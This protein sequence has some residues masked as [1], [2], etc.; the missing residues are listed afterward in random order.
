MQI[1]D[2]KSNLAA[3]MKIVEADNRIV[4]DS[5]GSYI[6][7]KHTG[8]RIQIRHENGC[9]VFDMWVPA[10]RE[11]R[12]NPDSRRGAKRTTPIAATRN[13][14]FKALEE[15]DDMEVGDI[16]DEGDRRRAVF[17]RQEC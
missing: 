5:D 6:E 16:G 8:D 14:R 1:A 13:N 4:L 2:V 12:V 7:N 11:G 9:F 10:R 15:E 17:V 3:G